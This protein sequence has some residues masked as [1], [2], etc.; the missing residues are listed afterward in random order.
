MLVSCL[1]GAV[2]LGSMLWA[3]SAEGAA[4][5]VA[6]AEEPRL[7]AVAQ[8]PAPP[9]VADLNKDPSEVRLRAHKPPP[10]EQNGSR[11]KPRRGRAEY[12]CGG[13]RGAGG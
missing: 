4:A 2:L 9:N 12:W 8:G 13:R 11:Q 6:V 3:A 1:V 7:A 5:G 10:P